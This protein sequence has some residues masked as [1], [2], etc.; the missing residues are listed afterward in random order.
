MRKEV[1]LLRTKAVNSLILSI[2]HFNRPFDR[3]RVE[4][5][6]IFLDHSFEMLLKA[7]ILH[8]GG[9]IREPRAKQTIGFDAC[10]R[11]A[12]SDGSIKF[13]TNVQALAPQT[14]N[15][16]RDA[17]QHHLVD[18]SEQHLYLQAQAGLTLFR[19]IFKKV[20]DIELYTELPARVLPLST[21]VPTDFETLFDTE[22]KEIRKLLYPGSR[23]RIEATAKL[24]ALAIVEGAV[25][26]EK[27]QPSQSELQKLAREVTQ[28]KR[29]N[30]IFPGVASVN[31]TQQGYGPSISLRITKKEGIPVR[32]VREDIPGAAVVGVKRVDEL[33]F[34]HLGRDQLAQKVGLTGPKTTAVIRYLELQSDPEC[35]KEFT[36]G[37]TRFQRYSQKAV[38]IIKDTLENVPISTIWESHGI[39]SRRK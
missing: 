36:I 30:Q 13:L 38:A 15:S 5:V 35:F 1:K 6:L 37:K 23:R 12:L 32:L 29:W 17:A 16:L 26:G 25:Q 14:I 18:I 2:E 34:Y 22:V 20:F 9:K 19:D 11:K 28:E 21:S 27:L 7:A 31:I 8:R 10:L 24:R 3:G 33:G 4:A 39:R